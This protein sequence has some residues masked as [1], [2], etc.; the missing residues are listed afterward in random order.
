MKSS[1]IHSDL[2][3]NAKSVIK[4]EKTPHE[5]WSA[6]RAWSIKQSDPTAKQVAVFEF[7]NHYSGSPEAAH[8]FPEV[9]RSASEFSPSLPEN[10]KKLL[11]HLTENASLTSK[12]A[13]SP[14][15]NLPSASLPLSNNR[16]S[17]VLSFEPSRVSDKPPLGTSARLMP[18][19]DIRQTINL[20]DNPLH[21]NNQL[22]QM[23]V[24]EVM[25]KKRNEQVQ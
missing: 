4:S 22:Y 7:L 14:I 2:W 12:W 19:A 11:I 15:V 25:K 3:N 17:P 13:H 6:L 20:R 21:V 10:E 1:D 18:S 23:Q 24:P 16:P 9:L 8:L 5:A